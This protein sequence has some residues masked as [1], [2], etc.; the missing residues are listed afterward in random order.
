MP[1]HR[2][3]P[4]LSGFAGTLTA[5]IA[6]AALLVPLAGV[7]GA[8]PG[9]PDNFFVVTPGAA[10]PSQVPCGAVA[11][12]MTPHGFQFPVQEAGGFLAAFRFPGAQVPA[13]LAELKL[14]GTYFSSLTIPTPTCGTGSGPS[15][16]G[17][18]GE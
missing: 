12:F 2:R 9:P 6:A 16:G 14:L 17:V 8:S 5:L 7:A 13:F 18:V 4:K 10:I 1:V 11:E 15:S 3:G